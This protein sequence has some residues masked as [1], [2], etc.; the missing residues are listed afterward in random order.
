MKKHLILLIIIL[1]SCSSNSKKIETHFNSHQEILDYFTNIISDENITSQSKVDGLQYTTYELINGENQVKL[2][3][4]ERNFRSRYVYGDISEVKSLEYRGEFDIITKNGS[5]LRGSISFHL[6]EDQSVT[7]E[8]ILEYNKYDGDYNQS[9]YLQVDSYANPSNFSILSKSESILN[10]NGHMLIMDDFMPLDNDDPFSEIIN[11]RD[12]VKDTI[13]YVKIVNGEKD[14]RYYRR[15]IVNIN[16]EF[17]KYY[18]EEGLYKN[19]YLIELT[20]RKNSVVTSFIKNTFQENNNDYKQSERITYDENNLY[21]NSEVGVV[22]LIRFVNSITDLSYIWNDIKDKIEVDEKGYHSYKPLIKEKTTYDH[23]YSE[24]DYYT[25]DDFKYIENYESYTPKNPVELSNLKKDKNDKL[26]YDHK[27]YLAEP[28]ESF[29]PKSWE[30]RKKTQIINLNSKNLLDGDYFVTNDY[31]NSYFANAKFKSGTLLSLEIK[32]YE[33]D[34][35]CE[36]SYYDN[37][38]CYFLKSISTFSGNKIITKK[39]NEKGEPIG[40]DDEIL[41]KD[42]LNYDLLKFKRDFDINF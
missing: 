28:K 38:S 37:T 21:L 25:A 13:A 36:Q 22:E 2:D 35:D 3:V 9:E 23:K 5:D 6:P 18:A 19:G 29:S 1:S 12:I 14:G 15:K 30:L 8:N 20:N 34:Y 42:N 24:N 31:H 16:G 33:E 4:S 7:P 40:E 26:V 10:R 17:I 32:D 27:S 39:F 11:I 41:I